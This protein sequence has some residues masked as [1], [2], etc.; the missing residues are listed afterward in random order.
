MEEFFFLTDI[1][2]II[3]NTALNTVA[4][5]HHWATTDYPLFPSMEKVKD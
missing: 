5:K 4:K 1:H 3:L 2:N